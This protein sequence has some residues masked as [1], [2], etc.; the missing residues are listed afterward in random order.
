MIRRILAL[1][2]SFPQKTCV[3]RPE[4]LVCLGLVVDLVRVVR[5]DLLVVAVHLVDPAWRAAS[6][7]TE[8]CEGAGGEPGGHQALHLGEGEDSQTQYE[9][10]HQHLQS[11]CLTVSAINTVGTALSRCLAAD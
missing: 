7:D 10:L 9:P 1:E 11:H 8:G 5:A 4:A 2:L 6:P 3:P